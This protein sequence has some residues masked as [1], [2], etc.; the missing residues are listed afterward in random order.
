MKESGVASAA[1]LSFSEV[2]PL[3]VFANMHALVFGELVI[4]GDKPPIRPA[5]AFR[6]GRNVR[7]VVLFRY[8]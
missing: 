2:Q 6:R 8:R 7:P 3:R 5:N 4:A 1:P